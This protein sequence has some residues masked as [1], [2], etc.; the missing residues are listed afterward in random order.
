MQGGQ[1]RIA[2]PLFASWFLSEGVDA[3]RRPAAHVA[4]ARGAVERLDATVPR[5]AL[6]GG[7][8]DRLTIQIVEADGDTRDRQAGRVM[9]L[10][11]RRPGVR[12]ATSLVIAS[13]ACASAP[14]RAPTPAA[15]SAG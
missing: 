5:G 11:D 9:R 14:T 12:T 10:L 4:V 8:A 7:L 6:G 13:T 3:L 1:R 2:R 15:P